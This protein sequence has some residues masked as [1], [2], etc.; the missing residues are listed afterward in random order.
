MADHQQTGS[1]LCDELGKLGIDV[2]EDN[3]KY[4][5]T[6]L[7]STSH[8]GQVFEMAALLDSVF[9]IF[10]TTKN[11]FE[12]LTAVLLIDCAIPFCSCSQPCFPFF[13]YTN[14]WHV[15]VFKTIC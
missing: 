3:A 6:T 10:Q 12:I 14:I 15:K 11:L 9:D 7:I 2:S 4:V 8:C 1:W 5:N 13:S